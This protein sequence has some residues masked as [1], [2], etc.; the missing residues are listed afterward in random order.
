MDF[1]LTEEQLM[2]RQTAREFAEGVLRKTAGERDK[3]ETF[4]TE[5]LKQLAELGFFG[6]SIPEEYGGA[7]MDNISYVIALEELSRIDASIGVILS[8]TNSLVSGLIHRSGSAYQKEKFLIPLAQGKYLGAFCLTEPDSGSDAASMR[9]I[10]ELKDNHYVLNGSKNFVTSG[11]YADVFV[12]MAITDNSKSASGI[13][14]FILPKGIKGLTIGAKEKKLGIRSSTTVS[15]T[16][17]DCRVPVIN[18]IGEEGLGFKIALSSLD[19]GRLGIAAQALGIA[20]SALEEATRYS[21][22]RRQFGRPI[23]EF[24]GVSFKLADMESR[25]QAARLLIYRT[26]WL[27]DQGKRYT[28]EAS[29]AKLFASETA[30]WATD[31]AL[32][33]HG[34]YGY[35]KDYLVERLFR[36]SRVTEIYEG[37]SEIQRMIISNAVLKEY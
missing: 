7:G 4:P 35:T 28:K 8:V 32:Q 30:T 25:I 20:Q 26:A 16:L 19:D 33:I 1:A 11:A 29:I 21:K 6:V 36:D 18:R 37:T 13:S 22:Q 34:G 15:L 5:E 27:K 31:L 23:S 24:Q 9:T 14:S 12:V 10:A 17:E 3:T 2:M